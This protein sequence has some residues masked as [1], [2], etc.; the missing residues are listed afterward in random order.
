VSE[1]DPDDD[2]V[3][4]WVVWHYRY[5]DERRERRNVTVGSY[6][7]EAEFKTRLEHETRRLT[8]AKDAGVA[9]SV[10]RISGAVLPAG[11][12]CQM[13]SGRVRPRPKKAR[14]RRRR[15]T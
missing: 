10:E 13:S 5:D 15:R 1:V 9:E 14:E 7:N 11:Y 12:K 2:D 8:A 3:D 4:R 6:D